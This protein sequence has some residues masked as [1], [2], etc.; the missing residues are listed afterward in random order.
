MVAVDGRSAA[1]KSTVA[2]RLREAIPGAWVVH[3]DDVA[4][5]HSFFG[6][7]DLLRD[8][9]LEP[10]R[11]GDLPVR[12]RPPAW[13]ERARPGAI[14]VPVGCRVLIVEGVGAGRSDLA[15]LVDALV[16]VQSDVVEA[17]RRGLIRDGGDEAAEAF[18]DEWDAEEVPFLELHAPWARADLVVCGT[19]E[20][21]HAA[22]P[23]LA[24][25]PDADPDAEGVLIVS[26]R[27]GS[28]P[29]A[30]A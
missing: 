16:W 30:D 17:R 11:R 20:V 15:D 5:W 1:G 9:V 12:Y 14:E 24:L 21:A 25:A 26:A 19:P 13:D 4:W 7:A 29:H 22:A 6:W 23:D 27:P 8:G 2:E 3:T 28:I 18:W 10:V